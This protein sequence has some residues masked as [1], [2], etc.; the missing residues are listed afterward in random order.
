MQGRKR[1]EDR[2]C[3]QLNKCCCKGRKEMGQQLGFRICFF[4]MGVFLYIDENDLE[5]GKIGDDA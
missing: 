3:R 4:K 1:S 5:K 2:K